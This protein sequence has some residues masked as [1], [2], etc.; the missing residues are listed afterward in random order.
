[1]KVT[2][3]DLFAFGS[4]TGPKP[5]RPEID[6]F[7]DE[8]GWL[9]PESPPLPRGMSTFADVAFAPLTGRYHRLPQ[10]TPP[11]EGLE[12]VADG[13][14]VHGRSSHEPTH[15]TIYPTSAVKVERFRDLY[16]GLPW[17]AAG[18]KS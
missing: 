8:Y 9:Q 5:P 1:M 17:I 16:L 14:D 10:G 7:P 15:H 11:P 12:V 4:S 13:K 2:P 18:K 6:V 3:A